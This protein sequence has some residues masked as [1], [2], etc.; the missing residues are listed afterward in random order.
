MNPKSTPNAQSFLDLL[1]ERA[2]PIHRP[3]P[4]YPKISKILSK[5]LT[6]TKWSNISKLRYQSE[7]KSKV[8]QLRQERSKILNELDQLITQE[9]VFKV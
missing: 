7:S 4:R 6:A 2:N 5:D 3:S 9:E 8:R 1:K